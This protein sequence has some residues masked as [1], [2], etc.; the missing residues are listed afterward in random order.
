MIFKQLILQKT[1]LILRIYVA[2]EPDETHFE[3]I[4]ITPAWNLFSLTHNIRLSAGWNNVTHIAFFL[5]HKTFWSLKIF[6]VQWHATYLSVFSRNVGNRP[7]TLF[8]KRLS[9]RY[10]PVNFVKF[11]RT[12]FLTEQLWWLL[13]DML[14]VV[15]CNCNLAAVEIE[16]P[17]G[18]KFDAKWGNS[19]STEGWIM[20]RPVIHH[21]NRNLTR[22]QGLTVI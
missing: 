11:L 22:Y 13:L 4:T 18:C 5:R 12:P 9:Y 21:I 14:G 19:Y 16:Y 1:L 7:V 17:N 6:L 8:K 10:F 2:R 3:E 15:A 20:W